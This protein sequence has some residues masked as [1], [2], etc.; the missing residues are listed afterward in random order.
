M[1][2]NLG[3]H[4]NTTR[5]ESTGAKGA[6]PWLFWSIYALDRGLSLRLGRPSVIQDYDITVPMP[7]TSLDDHDPI[8]FTDHW[9]TFWVRL[10]RV[11]GRVYELLYSP[12]ALAQ[13]D[14]ARTRRAEVLAGEVLEILERKKKT[15]VSGLPRA[16]PCMARGRTELIWPACR[17]S[18]FPC[19]KP[20]WRKKTLSS[21]WRPMTCCTIPS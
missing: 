20:R 9:L 16:L 5:D 11:E 4:R 13:D 10:A 14:E 1:C 3:L 18:T 21:S 7:F 19:G 12:G 17:I 8:E 15:Q 6:S 2:L